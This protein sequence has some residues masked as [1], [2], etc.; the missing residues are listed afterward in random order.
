M[1]F[2]PERARRRIDVIVDVT[3][4]IDV[5]FQLLIFFMVTTTFVNSPGLEVELP[6]AAHSDTQI[7]ATDLVVS[8]TDNGDIVYKHKRV[9]VD[10]LEALFES[11]TA[12]KRSTTVIIQADEI[13]QHGLVV[14]I[15]DAAKA[16]G[17]SKLAIATRQ[18]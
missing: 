4:L 11:E 2:T 5:V 3:P 1:D 7:E 14:K 16:A 10:E 13:V 17:F 18:E 8:V 9:S 12:D 15:M 6:K